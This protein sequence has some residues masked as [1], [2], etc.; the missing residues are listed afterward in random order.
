MKKDH[1][2]STEA[3]PKSGCRTINEL[4]TVQPFPA[5]GPFADNLCL[6]LPI[7]KATIGETNDRAYSYVL[8]TV[9]LDH[10]VTTFEQHGS[11]PNFQG[12]VLTL[13]TCK[14]QMRAT[15]TTEDWEGVW[16][17]GFTSRTIYDG[18]HWLFYLAKIDS[19]HE[20]HTD[21]WSAMR[22]STRNAKAADTHFLG[23]I[24]RPKLPT[25]TG[26]ARFSHNRY[27][28]PTAHA[29]RQH[30]GDKGWRND[31][32]YRHAEKYRHPPLLACDPKQTYL[33]D[34]PLIYFAGNHCRNFHKWS[35]LS[36]LISR[37]KGAR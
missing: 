26:N 3:K 19:A 12:S 16:V 28:M 21:L 10:E 27:V 4:Q 18:K 25:P 17:A 1:C 5:N 32:N 11:A 2:G 24:F 35:S 36:R 6:P 22:A 13:C 33:W 37:L 14:H 7:L 9:K 31:I 15:Q 34:E 23:D 8:S 20:S 29:H 30:R